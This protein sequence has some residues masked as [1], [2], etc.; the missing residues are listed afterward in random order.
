[1]TT[2]CTI[3][4]ARRFLEDVARTRTEIDSEIRRLRA[5]TKNVAI[6]Q[7]LNDGQRTAFVRAVSALP[8][9]DNAETLATM[10]AG[11]NW[12]AFVDHVIEHART[13]VN[14]HVLAQGGDLVMGE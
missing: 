7:M 1:M 10:P 5:E 8:S 14:R 3:A 2:S 9:F 13:A 11:N 12:P 4:D 6:R